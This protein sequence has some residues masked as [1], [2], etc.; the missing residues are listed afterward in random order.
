MTTITLTIPAHIVWVQDKTHI[1]LV[2]EA[3]N[4]VCALGGLEAAVWDWI[5]LGY[6]YS[7]LLD[8]VA[9]YRAG[10]GAEAELELTGILRQWQDRGW[11]E[12]THG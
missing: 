11:L 9:A 3:E 7:R 4:T 12:K 5:T 8:M 2:N 1:W 6:G 10:T